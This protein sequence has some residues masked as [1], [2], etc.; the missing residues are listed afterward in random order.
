MS[1]EAGLELILLPLFSQ[2]DHSMGSSPTVLFYKQP[3]YL[4]EGILSFSVLHHRW[5]R[6]L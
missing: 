1:A 5:E 6:Q 2:G 3:S 4:P